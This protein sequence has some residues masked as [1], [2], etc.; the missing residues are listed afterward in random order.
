MKRSNY[1]YDLLLTIHFPFLE[2]KMENLFFALP[3]LK[4]NSN[5]G[6]ELT[7]N[8]Y[9]DFFTALVVIQIDSNTFNMK[10]YQ[11]LNKQ[12]DFLLF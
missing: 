10:S 2:I 6:I 3:Q 12:F 8:C 7:F 1:Y 11:S 4:C 5:L 9:S